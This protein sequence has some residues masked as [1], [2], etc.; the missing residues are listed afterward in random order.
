MANRQWAST[1]TVSVLMPV[2]DP[3]PGLLRTAIASIV[4]QTFRDLELVVV[5]DPGARSAEPVIAGMADERI[6]FRRNPG[7]TGLCAQRNQA[8]SFA[9]GRFVA[10]MDAD[11]I[12][13]PARIERQVA[14]LR[15]HADIDIVGS[16]I[17]LIDAH[18]NAFARRRYPTEHDEIVDAMQRYNPLAQPSV[19]GRREII[20]QAGGYS[21]AVPGCEDYEL[22][23]RLATHGARFANL[24]DVLLRYRIHAGQLKQRRLRDTLAATIDIKQRY[25]GPRMGQRARLRL[26]AERVLMLL[27]PKLVMSLFSVLAFERLEPSATQ[28][29]THPG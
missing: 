5:E 20:E 24:P 23:C 6:V 19:M 27:P 8:L 25:F 13:L 22:W 16:Q 17:E 3:D 10:L 18:G 29:H 28:R 26:M 21:D 2:L 4:E 12:S 11:D 9:R 7:T 14:F 15:R 1:P